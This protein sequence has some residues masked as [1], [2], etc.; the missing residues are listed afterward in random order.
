MSAP[1]NIQFVPVASNAEVNY[2]GELSWINPTIVDFTQIIIQGN[3]KTIVSQQSTGNKIQVNGLD[4][5]ITYTAYLRNSA[6]GG[7]L[8]NVA[9]LQF[10]LAIDSKYYG[11]IYANNGYFKGTVYANNIV[12]D[13]Y[14]KMS[15]GISYVNLSD[16]YGSGFHGHR[17]RVNT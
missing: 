8:S 3:G 6:K 10:V 16:D 17:A 2:Q 9:T 11:D 14:N 4:R 5:G 12:G 13:V 7:I 15:G 1:T